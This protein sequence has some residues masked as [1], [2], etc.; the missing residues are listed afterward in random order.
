M[1]KVLFVCSLYHPHV[2]GIETMVS[3]LSKK[4]RELGIE[5]VVLTKKWPTTLSPKD[6]FENIKIFRT[7]SARTDE[8]F[9]E[10]VKFVKLHESELRADI[11]HVIGVRRP[12]PVIALA[13]S[14]RWSVPLVST[15]AGSEIPHEDDPTT[16]KEWS[17]NKSLLMPVL[18][19]S[20]VVT[21]VSNSLN[22]TLSEI[23]PTLTDVRTLYAGIDINLIDN[24]APANV[25]FRYILSLRR[26]IPSKGVATLISAFREV[27]QEYPDLRLTIAG[28]GP[29]REALEDLVLQYK[30]SGRIEFV[31]TVTLVEGIGLLK[32]AVCTVVPSLSEGGGLVNVEAQ[33]AYCPVIASNTGGIPEYVNPGVSGLLFTPGDVMELANCIRIMVNNERGLR[34]RLVENGRKHASMFSWSILAIEYINLYKEISQRS[35]RATFKPWSDLTLYLQKEL[36]T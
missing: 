14:A 25:D 2:G 4:Y 27:S 31:G 3:Q 6:S 28:D 30:L 10:L 18:E 32:S 35:V 24:A 11:I 33:A 8:E 22:N 21:C 17:D 13:L 12:L 26:L 29:E 9:A 1:K 7:V 5:S 20:D 16:L 23:V 36:L 15:V 19:Q 34:D